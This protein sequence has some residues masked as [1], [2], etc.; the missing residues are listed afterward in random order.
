MEQAAG[1]CLYLGATQNGC[2]VCGSSV[3]GLGKGPGI[4]SQGGSPEGTA[5]NRALILCNLLAAI[6]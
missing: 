5:T 3:T 1:R 4:G 6:C 2:D